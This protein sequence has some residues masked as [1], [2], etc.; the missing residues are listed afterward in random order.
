MFIILQTSEFSREKNFLSL[1]KKQ[2]TFEEFQ[3]CSPFA[4]SVVFLHDLSC[5][6]QVHGNFS[7][8][9]PGKGVPYVSVRFKGGGPTLFFKNSE[10]T[11]FKET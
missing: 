6:F 4:H 5:L 8:S 3:F 9:M 10:L 11:D 1:P 2:N 7:L